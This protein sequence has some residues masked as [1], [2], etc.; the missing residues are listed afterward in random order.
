MS[1][2]PQPG[3]WVEAWLSLPRFGVYLEATAGDRQLGGRAGFV[4]PLALAMIL[5]VSLR[6][7]LALS[8]RVQAGDGFSRGDGVVGEVR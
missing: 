2:N 1:T 8:G 6:W 7:V 3:P 5:V 4:Q